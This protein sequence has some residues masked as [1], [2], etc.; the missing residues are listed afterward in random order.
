MP[1]GLVMFINKYPSA[2]PD[3][4]N[5]P[6]Y[7]FSVRLVRFSVPQLSQHSLCY[8]SHITYLFLRFSVPRTR[9][10][11]VIIN[12][13]VKIFQYPCITESRTWKSQTNRAAQDCGTTSEPQEF[14]CPFWANKISIF[15]GFNWPREFPVGFFGY[16]EFFGSLIKSEKERDVKRTGALWN[17]WQE[18]HSIY[19]GNIS[20]R[21]IPLRSFTLCFGWNEASRNKI[22]H[23]CIHI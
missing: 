23:T 19:D 8:S 21:T 18:F 13:N 14:P 1:F 10:K 15:L 17:A 11:I 7:F 6:L 20:S 2:N 16:T 4:F 9:K 3:N 5:P 12:N 22:R